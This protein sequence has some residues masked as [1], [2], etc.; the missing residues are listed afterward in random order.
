ME[1]PRNPVASANF[2]EPDRLRRPWGVWVVF[3]FMV[4]S[5]A[6]VFIALA[7]IYLGK[8][9]L[10]PAQRAYFENLGA[11]EYLVSLSLVTINLVGAILLF[12]LRKASVPLFGAALAINLADTARAAMTSNYVQTLGG[13]PAAFGGLIIPVAVLLYA[14]WLRKKGV[15]H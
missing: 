15:L 11:F 12:R 13:A 7:L 5:A 3:L 6:W 14:A 9:G 4:V 8:V 10:N 2:A 1:N